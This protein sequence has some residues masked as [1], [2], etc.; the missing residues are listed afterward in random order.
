MSDNKP[1]INSIVPQILRDSTPS[2]TNSVASASSPVSPFPRGLPELYSRASK[3]AEQAVFEDQRKRYEVARTLY[4][5]VIQIF[6]DICQLEQDPAKR[7]M[8]IQKSQEYITR[9][10]QLSQILNAA[11]G[12]LDAS[13]RSSLSSPTE[14]PSLAS[15]P[16]TQLD[17]KLERAQF[18]LDQAVLHD[19]KNNT[20]D[21][22]ELYMDAAEWFLK[23]FKESTDETY[24]LELKSK[25]T[26]TANRVEELKAMQ[27][28]QMSIIV[29][30]I[31]S[32][33]SAAVQSSS[34]TPPRP[35]SPVL[36]THSAKS[37]TSV[38][39][40]ASVVSGAGIADA[41]RYTAQEKNLLTTTSKVNGRLYLP[42]DELDLK[43]KFSS[44]EPFM[45]LDGALPLS[46]KQKSKF[47]AWKRPSQIMNNPKMIHQI[48]SSNIVQDIVTDCSFVASL[49]VSAAYERKFNKQKI[50][51]LLHGQ[52]ESGANS[53]ELIITSASL[54]YIR[55]VIVD[56]YLP[57]SRDGTL[58]CTF[59]TNKEELWPSIIEKAV[60]TF[61]Y[62]VAA[63]KNF[64][65]DN[66]WKRLLAGQ[67]YGDA[68]ITIATGELTDADADAIGLVPTHAYA[69][70]GRRFLQ[71]KNP[72]SHKRWTGPFSHM[73]AASW[74]PELMRALDYDYRTAAQKDDAHIVCGRNCLAIYRPWPSNMGPKKDVYN[75][76]YNP[77][78]SLEV[79]VNDPKPAA[80]W[81]LL[82]K[83]I[84][85]KE[86]NK[87]YITLHLYAG[88]NGERVFYPG[89][90]MKEGTYVNSPHILV[91]FNAPQGT[92]RYTIVVSQHEKLRSLNF[93][94]RAYCMSAFN[95]ME[96]P[97]KY[98]FEQKIPGQWTEQTAGGNTSN[99]TYMNN[100][101]WRL[102]IPPASGPVAPGTLYHAMAILILEAPRTFAV[103]VK[104]VQGGKRVARCVG[105]WLVC[106]RLLTAEKGCFDTK[107]VL[108]FSRFL[109][110]SVSMKDIVVQSGDYR[111]GFCYCE[112]PDLRPGDYTVV[113]STFEAG[114]LNKFFLTIGCS[115]KFLVTPIP[116]EGADCWRE[117]NGMFQQRW[118]QPESS[119][120]ARRERANDREVGFAI[121]APSS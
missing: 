98:S 94:L 118:I 54:H 103:H 5:Q 106:L 121:V 90:P 16:R 102:T 105:F 63:L 50:A 52:R 41:P 1:I 28:N 61:L 3:A 66:V 93:T 96:V 59:S 33:Q 108:I 25:F 85:I 120:P 26:K 83:H 57:V 9:V 20:E 115:T 38:A 6:A 75:L 43:E 80:V 47:G 119:L 21:A 87:D 104:L 58:M 99:A 4:S 73:D 78:F 46:D 53:V 14:T 117:R 91:R 24:R 101:Q 27:K 35:P 65:R 86:E 116:L 17:L 82:S 113:A 8:V 18:S 60:R 81:L 32:N 97:K 12:S 34:S 109:P 55:L 13:Q 23:A 30:G 68:L 39:S 40:S 89:N 114:L 69:V 64:V 11:A 76:G 88:T 79:T 29:K 67:K 84:T 74:T 42:W 22:L 51:F 77:Q 31:F 100:P 49:C 44:P 56:D 71:V 36:S 10:E 92:S 37:I 15:R 112:V 95:L 62:F 72:W 7:S 107:W 2:P 45:D 110:C 19:E 48:S 70:L 111:H